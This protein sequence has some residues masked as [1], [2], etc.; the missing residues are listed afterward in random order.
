MTITGLDPLDSWLV[1]LLL[2]I[3]TVG[4]VLN[5]VRSVD[6]TLDR[7]AFRRR[8]QAHPMEWDR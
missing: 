7:R 1:A 3:T 4:I 8:N 6:R 2:V 5:A